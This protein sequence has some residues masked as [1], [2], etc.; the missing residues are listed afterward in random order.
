M[1]SPL[2]P[3]APAL[4]P[5]AGS[6]MFISFIYPPTVLPCRVRSTRSRGLPH[7]ICMPSGT[8]TSRR[9]LWPP[10]TESQQH[11]LNYIRRP[12]AGLPATARPVTQRTRRPR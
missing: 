7:N 9:Q 2:R 11:K 8:K 10:L 1:S 12:G 5:A 3:H 4:R 6:I